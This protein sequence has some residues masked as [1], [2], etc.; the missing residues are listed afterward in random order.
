MRILL[1]EDDVKIGSFIERGLKEAGFAVDRCVDGLSGLDRALSYTYD[2]A[3]IDIMLPKMDGLRVIEKMREHRIDV[4]V[5]IL[6]ARQS[7]DDRILGLQKGGDDYMV[8]PFSFSELLARVQALIRRDKKNSQPMMLTLDTLEMDLLKHEV[9][10]DG[11]KV[12][13]PAKEYALLEYLLRNSGIVVTKTSILERVY[14]YSFEPQTNVVDVLVCRLRNKIDK[15][16]ERKMIHTVR[17]VGYV[18]K[19]Q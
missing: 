8:K 17:G 15:G 6:S 10:R 7:V 12:E 18:L 13:L 14:D 5:L 16:F 3:V 4:P 9:Y 1:I 2:T 19:A 11:R